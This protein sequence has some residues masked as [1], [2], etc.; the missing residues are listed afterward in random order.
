[1]SGDG[2][3]VAMIESPEQNCLD[4]KITKE[5][6]KGASSGKSRKNR[7]SSAKVRSLSKDHVYIP[8]LTVLPYTSQVF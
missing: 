5:H 8:G 4:I 2:N 7:L 1:L 3:E 6:V